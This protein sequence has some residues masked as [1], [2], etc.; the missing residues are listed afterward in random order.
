MRSSLGSLS[1]GYCVADM[2]QHTLWQYRTPRRAVYL[3]LPLS[4][5]CS[6]A[7]AS[8]VPHTASH[9]IR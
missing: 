3:R 5:A 1:T 6:R 2:Q 8:S 9:C 4:C 7:Y